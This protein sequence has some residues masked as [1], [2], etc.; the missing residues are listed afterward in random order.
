MEADLSRFHGI[1]YVDRWRFDSQGY[2]KLTL[3][4][5]WVRIQ[6]LPGDAQIVRHFN[7][8]R[9]RWDDDTYLLSDL[10]HVL[11]GK[12]HPARPKSVSGDSKLSKERIARRAKAR[13]K[14]AAKRRQQKVAGQQQPQGGSVTD[15]NG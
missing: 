7:N 10:I 15:G 11:S 8:G 3:R 5:I 1:R 9:P 13:R 14:Y 2:R 4:E 6:Q 12:P